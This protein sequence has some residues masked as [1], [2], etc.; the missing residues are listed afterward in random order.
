METLLN[1]FEF[2]TR[3]M[4]MDRDLNP[5][6]SLFGGRALEWIDEEAAIFAYCQL[7]YPAN[8][9]TKVMSAVNFRAPA[10]KGDL[11]EIGSRTV[12]VGVTSVTIECLLRNKKTKEEIVHLEKIVFVNLL[13]GRPFPHNIPPADLL[14]APGPSETTATEG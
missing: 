8:L 3:K 14:S 1:N 9:V 6:G 12:A 7:K 11:L 4:V 13:N 5:G 10:H 2:H